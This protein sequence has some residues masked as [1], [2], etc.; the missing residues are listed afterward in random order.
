VTTSILG[1]VFQMILV[2]HFV[3]INR[4]SHRERLANLSLWVALIFELGVVVSAVSSL[5]GPDTSHAARLAGSSHDGPVVKDRIAPLVISAVSA[6]NQIVSLFVRRECPLDALHK[7]RIR[8]Y[9]SQIIQY[10]TDIGYYV[11]VAIL[12]PASSSYVTLPLVIYFVWSNLCLVTVGREILPR[13][14]YWV[15]IGYSLAYSFF[16]YYMASYIGSV[17]P[18]PRW[19]VFQVFSPDVT[20]PFTIIFSL[21]LAWSCMELMTAPGWTRGVTRP[22]PEVLKVA[23]NVL[24]FGVSLAIFVYG[25]AFPS[26]VSI[27][28]MTVVFFASFNS[29]PLNAK[30]FFP[31]LG[32]LFI[33]SFVILGTTQYDGFRLFGYSGNVNVLMFLQIFGLFKLS[34]DRAFTFKISG[35]IIVM[36]LGQIGRI[37]TRR[38]VATTADRVERK[39]ER[40]IA[41]PLAMAVFYVALGASIVTA[42]DGGFFADRY[43]FQ[44]LAIVH[45]VVVLLSLYV[46]PVFEFLTLVSG[47]HLLVCTYYKAL[48]VQDCLTTKECMPFALFGRMMKSGLVPPS[49]EPLI[50]YVWVTG[51]VY[52][53]NVFLSRKARFLRVAVPQ[54]LRLLLCMALV[55]MQCSYAF[56]FKISLFSLGYLSARIAGFA[57]QIT[58]LRWLEI[59]TVFVT[60]LSGAVQLGFIWMHKGIFSP[61][62]SSR[63]LWIYGTLFNQDRRYS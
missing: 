27:F 44:I 40:A 42:L 34:E 63:N 38:S 59:G 1:L 60:A 36:L 26:L 43:A 15:G 8:V 29:L 35:Y 3:I 49:G 32:V 52:L 9:Q 31:F 57:G 4:F 48:D 5:S 45:L 25:L 51:S 2:L 11:S 53:I 19:L 10:V 14:L 46:R 7:L 62:C 18:V 6:F 61:L 12:V 13:V 47:G 22:V 17:F 23:R 39:I 55:I 24:L 21:A 16:S 33:L 20:N 41:S 30:F 54:T 37:Q 28:W 58:Q 50:D 56:N